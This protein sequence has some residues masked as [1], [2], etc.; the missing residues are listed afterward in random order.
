MLIH[1]FCKICEHEIVFVL[2]CSTARTISGSQLLQNRWII[3][4]TVVLLW[5]YWRKYESVSY[6]FGCQKG[7]VCPA[8]LK[9]HISMFPILGV[10]LSLCLLHL[11]TRAFTNYVSRFFADFY[12]LPM[13]AIQGVLGSCRFHWCGVHCKLFFSQTQTNAEVKEPV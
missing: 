13:F 3:K 6:S 9:T 1:T 7:E 12:Y 10:N 11:G 4:Q 2:I 8:Q 5:K